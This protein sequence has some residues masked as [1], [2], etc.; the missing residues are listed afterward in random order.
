M[1]NPRILISIIKILVKAIGKEKID[2]VLN[3]ME[4]KYDEGSWKDTGMEAAAKILR[5]AL[6][7]PDSNP[8][9]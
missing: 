8:E 3:E 7:V 1:M 4:E 9:N 2:E 5:T 6:D